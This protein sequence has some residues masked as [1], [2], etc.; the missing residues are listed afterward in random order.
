MAD[1]CA[2][3]ILVSDRPISG[4]RLDQLIRWYDAQ[5]RSEEQLAD[6]LAT[7]DLTEAAQKNRARAR[8]HR[9]TVLALS[10]LQPAP[11]PPVTEFRAHLTTKE[12]PRAQVRAPP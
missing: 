6:A 11:E 1:K 9:D 8:A 7:S 2:I 5:A 10:L 12:R 4:P 3:T